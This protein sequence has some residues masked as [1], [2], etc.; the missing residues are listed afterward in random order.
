M[1][2]TF[3]R[4]KYRAYFAAVPEAGVNVVLIPSNEGFGGTGSSPSSGPRIKKCYLEQ[5]VH[6][7]GQV[8]SS[9]DEAS[10]TRC[11]HSH[12]TSGSASAVI[13]S[14]L[15]KLT[16][17]LVMAQCRELSAIETAEQLPP[18]SLAILVFCPTYRA[19]ELVHSA[20]DDCKVSFTR[21]FEQRH[22]LRV[23]AIEQRL[24]AMIAELDSL[25]DFSLGGNGKRSKDEAAAREREYSSCRAELAAAKQDNHWSATVD[26][27]LAVH[28]L[29]SSL[30]VEALS[31]EALGQQPGASTGEEDGIGGA[32]AAAASSHSDGGST[33]YGSRRVFLAT[34]IAESSVTIPNLAVVIDLARANRVFWDAERRTSFARLEWASQDACEQRR[35]RTGRTCVGVAYTLVPSSFAMNGLPAYEPPALQRG[36]LREEALAA[37]CSRLVRACLITHACVCTRRVVSVYSLLC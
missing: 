3:E 10:R 35:G 25:K 37:L 24:S 29:H 9:G 19:I 2:A 8:D 20:L 21:R 34:S 13:G 6:L 1:S 7:L 12:P 31:L 27:A 17:D 5:A 14:D 23:A 22:A 33:P 15:L 30:D 36:S 18:N 11:L 28:V 16:G 4:D 32:A 26:S